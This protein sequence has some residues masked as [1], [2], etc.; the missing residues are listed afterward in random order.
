MSGVIRVTPEE[1]RGVAR[2]YSNESQNVSDLI[3][4]LD[5][6][7]GHLESIWEGSSSRA[8]IEQYHELKPSFQKMSTL[9]YEI[10]EQLNT[11]A[12]ILEETDQNIANQIRG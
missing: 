7:A 8:F 3:G 4:R 5:Q 12:R 1:L 11:T 9:L 10:H 2:Q 6:M